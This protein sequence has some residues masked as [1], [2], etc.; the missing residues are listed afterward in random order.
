MVT[1]D[2]RRSNNTIG[3]KIRKRPP[4]DIVLIV[5]ESKRTEYI[6]FNSLIND[7]WKI[8][9]ITLDCEAGKS[10]KRVVEKAI[11]LKNERIDKAE[12]SPKIVF[13]EVWC[14]IDHEGVNTVK[15]LP[16]AIEIADK[17]DIKIALSNPCFELWYLL[18]F[19]K[20]AKNPT[21]CKEIIY[22]LEKHISEY[23]KNKNYIDILFP[24]LDTAI[25]NASVLCS[26]EPDIKATRQ[27]TTVYKLVEKLKG[28]KR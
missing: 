10:P 6:Y 26:P 15:E 14:V 27:Y 3:R 18:H 12:I 7:K 19:K 13:D 17:N 5:F 4:N 25:K 20:K 2:R 24:K 11:S 23:K 8:A 9:S 22:E 1:K 28:M 21:C 16:I